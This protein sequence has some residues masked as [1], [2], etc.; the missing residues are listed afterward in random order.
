MQLW[1]F[2]AAVNCMR[3]AQ[4]PRSK[5]RSLRVAGILRAARQ[6]EVKY[7]HTKFCYL[8]LNFLKVAD[9]EKYNIHKQDFLRSHKIFLIFK[10]ALVRSI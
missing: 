2:A 1:A 6:E 7:L 10:I 8:V 5:L 3:N 4:S 9:D